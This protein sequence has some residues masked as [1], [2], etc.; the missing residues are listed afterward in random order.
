MT[1]Y[2]KVDSLLQTALFN[3]L[4]SYIVCKIT[5]FCDTETKINWKSLASLLHV[6]TNSC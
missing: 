4:R 1:Y 5:F 6:L 3:V 2:F